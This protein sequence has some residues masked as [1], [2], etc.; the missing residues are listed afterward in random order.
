MI[1]SVE[2]DMVDAIEACAVELKRIA[3]SLEKLQSCV[4]K[5]KNGIAYINTKSGYEDY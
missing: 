5:G 2:D 1:N 4:Q 3:N